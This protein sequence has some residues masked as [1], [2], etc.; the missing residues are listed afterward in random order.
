MRSIDWKA[1]QR[2]RAAFLDGSAGTRDYWQSGSDLD[3]YDQTFGQRIRWK[4]D[5]VLRELQQRGWSPPRGEV[6]DWGCGTGIACRALL[7]HFGVEQVTRVQLCDRSDM[8]M[9]YAARRLREG[10]PD[11][12]LWLESAGAGNASTL[13]VS[14]VLNELSDRQTEELRALAST[15]IAVIWVEPGTHEISRRLIGIRERLRG[16]FHVVAPCPHQDACGLLTPENHRHWCHHF[17]PSPPGVFTDGDWARF[18]RLA[19][20]DLRSLPVS[21]LVLDRRPAPPLPAGVT[22]V[23]GRPRVYKAHAL[24]LRCDATGVRDC[25]LTKR[26]SPEEFRRLKKGA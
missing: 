2:L 5:Y 13:L 25:R 21:F 17:V 24:V 15:A 9:Q 22:R 7:A 23:I 4:W 3:S 8:A 19:G 6:L 18:G 26:E 16:Q 10:F 12:N 1:L 14:H 20:V 11:I